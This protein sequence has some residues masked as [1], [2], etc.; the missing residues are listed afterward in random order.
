MP[1]PVVPPAE[2]AAIV[3]NADPTPA[4]VPS[5][6]GEPVAPV[7]E[8]EEPIPAEGTPK[9]V[10]GAEPTEAEK[11]IKQLLAK[12]KREE[13]LRIK[14]EQEAQYWRGV[15]EGRQPVPPPPS[16]N[17]PVNPDAP[18]DPPDISNFEKFADYEAAKEKYLVDR[19]KWEFRQESKAD[20]QRKKAKEVNDNWGKK[21]QEAEKKYDDFREVVTNPQFTQTEAVAFFIKESDNGA[22]IAYYLATHLDESAR[23]NSLP[24]HRAAIEIG[25]LE[26]K[27]AAPKPAEPKNII[28]QAPEPIKPVTPAPSVEVDEDKLSIEEFIRRRNAKEAAARKGRGFIR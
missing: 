20:E 17:A 9:A 21:L 19:A 4:P 5:P 3:E 22:D 13:E 7:I 26:A 16:G 2:D 1:D 14:K 23:I 25:K 10:K 18:P 24:P 28:S 15:A 8:G 6:E 12:S 11:R 27:L